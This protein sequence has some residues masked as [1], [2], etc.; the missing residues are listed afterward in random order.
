MT[1]WFAWYPPD[2]SHRVLRARRRKAHRQNTAGW[3]FLTNT[4]W[5]VIGWCNIRRKCV[6]SA[7]RNI[8]VF[9]LPSVALRRPPLW[10]GGQEFLATERRCIVFPRSRSHITTDC[11][12]ASSSWC[13]APFGASDQMLHLFEWQLL[14]YFSCRAPSLTR[15]WVCNLQCNDGSSI[16][17]YIATYGLSASSSWWG[18]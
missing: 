14:S 7:S 13:L 8:N 10:S 18:P 3:L 16:S 12:P 17:S 6:V 4:I 11:R 9:L 1:G 2:V 5:R 15:G